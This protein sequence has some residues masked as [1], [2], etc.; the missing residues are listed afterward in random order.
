MIQSITH[1]DSIP[2]DFK[3]SDRE[4]SSDHSLSDCR[5]VLVFSSGKS[6][7]TESPI[8]VFITVREKTYT[9]PGVVT[10][11]VKTGMTNSITTMFPRSDVE[12]K[13]RLVE[14]ICHIENYR[15][16]LAEKEGRILSGHEAAA[17]W[18]ALY[19][20]FFPG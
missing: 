8:D 2:I 4:K 7:Q 20:K 1:P 3:I 17:E 5:F 14:Q 6:V 9:F 13:V 16:I 10:D 19:A 18:I 15:N 12:F 11:F